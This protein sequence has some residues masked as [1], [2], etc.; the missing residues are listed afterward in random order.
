MYA[1]QLTKEEPIMPPLHQLM[2]QASSDMANQTEIDKICEA[3][4]SIDKLNKQ[5][6]SNSRIE[7]TK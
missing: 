4:L 5:G 1:T 2:L 6:Q 7:V 3:F